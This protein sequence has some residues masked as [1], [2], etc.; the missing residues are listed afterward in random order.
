M[1]VAWIFPFVLAIAILCIAAVVLCLILPLLRLYRRAFE[2]LRHRRVLVK[3]TSDWW[4]EFERD[5]RRW[6]DRASSR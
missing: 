4:P 2:V 5:L 6:I 1:I 3:P